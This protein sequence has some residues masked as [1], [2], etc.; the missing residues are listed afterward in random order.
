MKG[1]IR[2]TVLEYESS[3]MEF[4]NKNQYM[5]LLAEAYEFREQFHWA[6]IEITIRS[7]V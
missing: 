5:K 7:K 4:R 2:I 6:I 1:K 3:E